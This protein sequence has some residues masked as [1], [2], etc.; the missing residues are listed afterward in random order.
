MFF[1]KI[2]YF[3][4]ELFEALV[5]V[6]VILV[7]AGLILELE[8]APFLLLVLLLE[9]VKGIFL[10]LIFLVEMLDPLENILGILFDAL[11]RILKVKME[12]VQL[13]FF[14]PHR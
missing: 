12:F 5:E 3:L 9:L 14:V 2:I 6:L 1:K 4:I 11:E 10:L 8:K 13:F 7:V